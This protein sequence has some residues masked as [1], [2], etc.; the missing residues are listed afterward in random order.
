[1]TISKNDEPIEQKLPKK[2]ANDK[3]VQKNGTKAT[4][5][6]TR[7]H[8]HCKSQEELVIVECAATDSNY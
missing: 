2:N 3:F 4:Q 6:K 8:V 5:H 1:M 7:I